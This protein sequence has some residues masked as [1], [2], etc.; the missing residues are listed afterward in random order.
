M[1]PQTITSEFDVQE[2]NDARS[3][4]RSLT[5]TPPV[6]LTIDGGAEVAM[7]EKVHFDIKL[8]EYDDMF[9]IRA[10]KCSVQCK[11]EH[12]LDKEVCIYGCDGATPFCFQPFAEFANSPTT[13]G[14]MS[15]AH[16]SYTAFKWETDEESDVD[17]Q[18]VVCEVELSTEVMDYNP[19]GEPDRLC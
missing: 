8:E 11:S 10:R 1:G 16:Y 3:L 12:C 4:T 9:K 14:Q 13:D 19:A 6:Q 7:G 2:D 5:V 18:V 17:M 15:F